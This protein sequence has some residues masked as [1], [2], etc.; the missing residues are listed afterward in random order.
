MVEPTTL[1]DVA[2]DVH[3][4]VMRRASKLILITCR[5]TT[6]LALAACGNPAGD[7]SESI[8]RAAVVAPI[9]T[10]RQL[11]VESQ[12]WRTDRK[13]LP[14]TPAVSGCVSDQSSRCSACSPSRSQP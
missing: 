12:G 14:A 5:V 13:G 9:E 10:C 1:P 6:T 2:L 3:G 4:V 8:R 7:D 11:D